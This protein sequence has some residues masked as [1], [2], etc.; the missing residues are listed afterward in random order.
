MPTTRKSN[1]KPGSHTARIFAE[2]P[3]V[4][5]RHQMAFE[6]AVAKYAHRLDVTAIDIGFKIKGGRHTRQISVRIHVREKS[7]VGHLTARERFPK[8]IDGIP[9][10]VIEATYVH[11]SGGGPP[12]G[13]GGLLQPGLSVGLPG[14]PTGTLGVIATSPLTNATC[15][16]SAAHV[17]AAGDETRPGDPV[18]QPGHADGG[19]PPRDVVGALERIDFKNDAA[20]AI[21]NDGG[22]QVKNCTIGSNKVIQGTRYPRLNDILE[23]SGR[24]TCVTQ[25]RI[26]GI[27]CF[28]G[29]EFAFRLVPVTGQTT[30]HIAEAGDSG[31][32]WYDPITGVGVGLHSKGGPLP[33][34]TM[35]YA[36]AASLKKVLDSW[37][38]TI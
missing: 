28:Y 26:D 13:Q 18:I 21:L 16:V 10:D 30:N 37:G 29:V 32:V 33:V 38:L 36:V 20:Y 6:K 1:P 19:R 31:A 15:L 12:T 9:V 24:G 7:K 2:D 4:S 14:G 27:G 3:L 34:G 8:T 35:N 11:A 22:R 5:D 25:G 17:I 23:K